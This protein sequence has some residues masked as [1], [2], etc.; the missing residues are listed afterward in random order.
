[1]NPLTKHLIVELYGCD[2][3]RISDVVYKVLSF[4]VRKFGVTKYSTPEIKQ[5]SKT[6]G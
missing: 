1:M 2:K 6:E 4:L 3:D 5:G